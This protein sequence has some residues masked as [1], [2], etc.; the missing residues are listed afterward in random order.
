MVCS[1]VIYVCWQIYE[2]LR[3]GGLS[4]F[5]I[6]V[7]CTVFHDYFYSIQSNSMIWF[8]IH[9]N[10]LFTIGWLLLPLPTMHSTIYLVSAPSLCVP[11]SR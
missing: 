11:H 6:H 4:H 1:H 7:N 9:I 10:V 3:V 2:N 5:H 8:Y